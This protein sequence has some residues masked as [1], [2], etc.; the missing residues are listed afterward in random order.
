MHVKFIMFREDGNRRDY[1]IAEGTTKIGRQSDCQIR[2]PLS[3]IS[4]RHAEVIIEEHSA[5]LRDLGSANGTFLNEERVFTDEFLEAG[6]R[7]VIGPVA[8]IVQIDDDPSDAEVL[9]IHNAAMSGQ[10]LDQGGGAVGTSKHVYISD[11]DI[12][13]IAALEELASSADHTAINADEDED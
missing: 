5:T 8:F 6:D 1:L 10:A 11:E 2:I 4:R 3:D 7:I 12:D 13:P 9:A